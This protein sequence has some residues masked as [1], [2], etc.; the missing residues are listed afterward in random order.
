MGSGLS[1]H[2][3]EETEP[4]GRTAPMGTAE[5]E[6]SAPHASGS[7][8]DLHTAKGKFHELLRHSLALITDAIFNLAEPPFPHL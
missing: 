3:W 1:F 8:K 2:L 5:G 7:P 4:S 6:T